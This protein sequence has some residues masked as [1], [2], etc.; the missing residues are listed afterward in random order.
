MR[1]RRAFV[2]ILGVFTLGVIAGLILTRGGEIA[3]K[4]EPPTPTLALVATVDPVSGSSKA[5][6][7]GPAKTESDAIVAIFNNW[8]Q[9]AFVDPKKWGEDTF[10]GFAGTFTDDAKASFRRDLASLT[11]AEARTELK[12]VEEPTGTIRVTLYFD[13]AGKPQYAVAAVTF[14]AVGTLKRK[15]AIPLEISQRGSFFLRKVGGDWKVFSFT[16]HQD[17]VQPSPSPTASPTSS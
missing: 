15:G 12:R 11:I 5:A 13:A 14:K 3:K 2:I 6:P 10:E 1:R 16:A 8:Y 17:Q 4:Q 7:A 9:E